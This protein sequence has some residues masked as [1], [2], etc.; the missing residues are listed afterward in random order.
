MAVNCGAISPHLAESELFGHVAGAF[1]GADHQHLGF[2]ER[3]DG[4]MLFLD[5]ITGMPGSTQV[6]LLRVLDTGR[7]APVGA[8][9]EIQ[10]HMR[11]V[12]ATNCD[13]QHAIRSGKL[14]PDLYYRLN[15]FPICLPRLRERGRDIELLAFAFVDEL[16]RQHGTRKS[17][18]GGQREMLYTYP[19]PGNV[20]ELRNDVQ[21]AHVMSGKDSESTAIVPV[22]VTFS[23]HAPEP[24]TPSASVLRSV[25]QIGAGCG[26]GQGVRW[27][28]GDCGEENAI[29][30]ARRVS[31]AVTTRTRSKMHKC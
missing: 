28:D 16:N 6:K 8:T 20:R 12:A 24:H 4:G 1:T 22:P 27:R 30:A 17:I 14:R 3:A 23:G 15:V 29:P 7:V 10:T 31:D 18:P 2:F 19:W 11:V 25:M 21:R 26:H 9:E 13:P 5:E